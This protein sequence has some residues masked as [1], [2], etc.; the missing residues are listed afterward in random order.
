MYIY[1]YIYICILYHKSY[2]IHRISY[3][4]DYGPYMAFVRAGAR[5][6]SRVITN[7][8]TEPYEYVVGCFWIALPRMQQKLRIR[9]SACV[10][11]ATTPLPGTLYSMGSS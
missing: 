8:V 9:P 5:F 2:V 6:T 3:I 10:E 4:L 1:I 7:T 11:F